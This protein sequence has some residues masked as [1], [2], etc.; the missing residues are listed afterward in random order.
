MSF[1]AAE[2]QHILNGLPVCGTVLYVAAHPD[3]ENTR[4][5]AYLAK[6]KHYTTYYLSL[7]KGEGGQNLIG[8]DLGPDLGYIRGEELLAARNTDGGIQLIGGM[9][10]FGFS[11]SADSTIQHWGRNITVREMVK[12]I[13]AIKPDVIITRFSPEPANTHGHHTASAILAVE[14]AKVA[15]RADTADDGSIR[16]GHTVKRVFWNISSFF[17]QGREKEFN[18]DKY[19]KLDVGGYNKLLGKNYSE[20]A[21]ESRSQHKSQGFG[22]ATSRGAVNEYFQLL[23]G[24]PASTDIMEGIDLTWKRYP[25]LMRVDSLVKAASQAYKS[26]DENKAINL[27]TTAYRLI[28]KQIE[29]P[30]LPHVYS[31]VPLADKLDQIR[32]AIHGILG[33]RLEL[34]RPEASGFIGQKLPFNLEVTNRSSL[35]VRLTKVMAN[36][37]EKK[38]DTVLTYNKPYA[39]KV[40]LLLPDVTV[41]QR[42]S[43]TTSRSYLHTAAYNTIPPGREFIYNDLRGQAQVHLN[44]AGVVIPFGTSTTYKYV[45]QIKGERY[46]PYHALTP[47]KLEPTSSL[48]FLDDADSLAIKVTALADLPSSTVQAEYMFLEN[49]SFRGVRAAYRGV[50][51]LKAGQSVV[52][53]IPA[54][55]KAQGFDHPSMLVLKLSLAGG[56]GMTAINE[57]KTYDHIPCVKVFD[58]NSIVRYIDL[59]RPKASKKVGYVM[60]AGDDVPSLLQTLGYSVDLLTEKDMQEATLKKYPA[61]LVGVRAYNVHNWLKAAKP[62]I[63][64][65]VKQGGNWVVQYNTANWLTGVDAL[66]SIGPYPLK[67]SAKRVTEQN[68]VVTF[69]NPKARVLNVPNKLTQADFSGWSVERGLYYASTWAPEYDAP[70]AMHDTGEEPLKGGLLTAKLGKGTWT[71]TGLSIFRQ[72]K[73]LAGPLRVLQNLVELKP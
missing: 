60:G 14:A 51:A 40:E 57:I 35:P 34:T 49:N 59:K 12:I 66:D 28:N 47:F 26:A 8:K 1:N 46:E 38:L 71:Y 15:A 17:F 2:T 64:N 56:M 69:L 42:Y 24:E 4:L 37:Y 65:Y 23:H 29:F 45:D 63:L 52:V 41:T 27:L 5:I 61:I 31:S 3:D 39:S 62:T 36:G 50:P 33:L 13:R 22:S 53:N 48:V 20:I 70:T 19:L 25:T 18:P 32:N 10:D 55:Q 54:R 73:H 72:P 67:I 11:K 30:K 44:I 43:H 16:P 21:G 68:S 6:E 7:T 58:P 9:E